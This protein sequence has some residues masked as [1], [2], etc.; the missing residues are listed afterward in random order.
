MGKTSIERSS[1]REK[2]YQNRHLHQKLKEHDI[3]RKNI[4]NR[5][6]AEARKQNEK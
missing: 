1:E 5:K 3:N 2:I 4:S 6:A